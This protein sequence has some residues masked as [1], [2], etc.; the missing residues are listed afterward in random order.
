MSLS[1]F[2]Y[3]RMSRVPYTCTIA[4]MCICAS[5]RLMQHHACTLTGVATYTYIL[6]NIRQTV[7]AI[8]YI[9]IIMYG[10]RYFRERPRVLFYLSMS[11][12][13]KSIAAPVVMRSAIF[14]PRNIGSSAPV[15]VSPI[16]R[17]FMR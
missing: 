13:T 15:S 8:L 3:T 5:A 14:C 7:V 12:I 1:P 2:H 4:S 17:I 10:V 6:C 16:G 11:G 9:Y